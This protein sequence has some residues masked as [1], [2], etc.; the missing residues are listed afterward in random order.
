MKVF[1]K[2]LIVSA[3]LAG[4][5]IFLFAKKPVAPQK[6]AP[7]TQA[8]TKPWVEVLK[9][10]AMVT[11]LDG[12]TSSLQTGDEVEAGDVV[13]TNKDGL[14]NIYFPDGSVIRLDLG[15]ELKIVEAEYDLQNQKLTV[16]LFVNLGR[17]WSKII[18]L[19]TPDSIWEVNTSNAVA[20]VRG[21]AFGVEFAQGKTTI[22]GS[23]HNVA[24]RLRDPVT[25]NLSK[26]EVIISPN[27]ILEVNESLASSFVTRN[28]SPAKLVWSAPSLLLNKAW[29]KRA[30]AADLE[31]NK[32][33]YLFNTSTLNMEKVIDI[34]Q[35]ISAL[36]S[37]ANTINPTVIST[38]FQS[39][40][41]V[42][43]FI[44][45]TS[46]KEAFITTSTSDTTSPNSVI[47]TNNTTSSSSSPNLIV[48][49]R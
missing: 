25:K 2:I 30:K 42:N 15:T 31:L 12:S 48:P 39:I 9:P 17:V 11:K 22:I 1:I 35:S 14:V 5:A 45:V 28:T 46:T 43:S 18:K 32:V 13:K 36:E 44:I 47:N 38:T 23:E 29:I 34:K 3:V 40:T 10:V 26:E 19:S 6:E 20:T 41:N 16:K 21:T 37:S 24:V 49:I 7:N 33:L 27:K 4:A 8:S